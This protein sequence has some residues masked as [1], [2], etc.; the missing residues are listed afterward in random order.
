MS[1]SNQRKAETLGMPGGTANNRLKKKIIYTLLLMLK[2]YR[3]KFGSIVEGETEDS[4]WYYPA[5][6]WLPYCSVCGKEI[7][8]ED[9]MTIE[10]IKPWEGRENGKDLYWDLDNIGFSHSWCNR[11]HI[12]VLVPKPLVH[13]WSNGYN[14]KGCR[15]DICKEGARKHNLQRYNPGNCRNSPKEAPC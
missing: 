12:A 4:K 7:A 8:S 9:D 3:E 13:G 15:C 1:T 10:H 2:D 11:P 6:K 14:K 5:T